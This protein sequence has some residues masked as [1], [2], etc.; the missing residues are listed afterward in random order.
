M[1]IACF[2]GCAMGSIF[3][4]QGSVGNDICAFVEAGGIIHA[5]LGF[6]HSLGLMPGISFSSYLIYF[7]YHFR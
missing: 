7:M 3:Q 2:V 5:C 6:Q 4:K 1:A